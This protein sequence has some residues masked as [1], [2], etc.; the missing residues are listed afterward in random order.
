MSNILRVCDLT[1]S[2]PH[3]TC[4]DGF[5]SIVYPGDRI[6]IIGR[7]GSGK[8]SLLRLIRNVAGA[9][10]AAYIPQ[11]I[12]DYDSCSGGERFNRALSAALSE[13]PDL[14]LLDEPTNHLDTTNKR[15]LIR[16]LQS[17]FGM[18]IVVTHDPEVLRSCVDILW[19]I[20]DGK[21]TVFNGKYDDY[22]REKQTKYNSLMKQRDALA[23]QK[24]DA[25]DH[26]MARQERTAKSKA[27][28][29]K[30]VEN[31]R[32]MKSVGD[33]K[34]MKAEVAQGKQLSQI[35]KKK[36]DIAE[37]MQQLRL[38]EVIVPKFNLPAQKA[39]SGAVL[40]IR[41]GAVGYGDKVIVRNI[42]LSLQAGQ[43]LAITGRNGSGKTTLLKAIL[44]N[45]GGDAVPTDSDVSITGDWFVTKD[46]GFLDQ[47]Y[48]TLDLN[49]SAL[50]I[51]ADAAPQW[52]VA[53]RRRHLNDFL[54]RK[55]EEVNTLVK[56]LS[57]GERARLSLAQIAANPP[58]LLILD[59]IT[60]NLDIETRGHVAQVLRDFPGAMLIVSH[61][62]D[63][64]REI[65][66]EEYYE[67][68]D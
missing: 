41:D 54:F 39:A 23:R 61:D 17:F 67:V 30:K 57:G 46:I 37:Q 51:I 29:R 13:G 2:F 5:S 19:H 26:L 42:S 60:N 65:R 4:F 55:N 48:Q 14:L 40:A 6:A 66:I 45:C 35:D 18:L 34:G 47:H 53:D 25:H 16:K 68:A 43:R 63:F 31:K 50:E 27:A 1:V 15:G 24:A 62:A 8:S 10:N 64:L 11:I 22:M 3:K 12:T 38:P 28:G 20:D 7:N 59:E 49:K 9:M 44:H 52:D 56:N 32:W 33:L 21:V 58:K 36:Q